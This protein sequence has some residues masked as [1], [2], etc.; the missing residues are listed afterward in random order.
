M[1]S[2][3]PAVPLRVTVRSGTAEESIDLFPRD[4]VRVYSQP[5][6]ATVVSID[7]NE[8]RLRVVQIDHTEVARNNLR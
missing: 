6:G 4:T 8:G 3:P 2:L 7:N 1:R 5:T